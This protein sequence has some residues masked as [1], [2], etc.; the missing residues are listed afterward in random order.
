MFLVSSCSC[1]YSIRWSQVL[2]REWR[3]SW[4]SADRRCSNYIWEINNFIAFS[5][6][7]YIRGLTVD[8][9]STNLTVSFYNNPPVPDVYISYHVVILTWAEQI[10]KRHNIFCC[11]FRS[12][13]YWWSACSIVISILKTWKTAIMTICTGRL[14]EMEAQR[15][16]TFSLKYPSELKST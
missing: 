3:C 9:P 8:V 16:L 15:G 4:S 11:T 1:L 5:D 13:L 7:T 6:A 12:Q 2:S 14:W 10:D